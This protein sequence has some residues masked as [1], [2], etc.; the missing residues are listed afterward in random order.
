ML[1][2][3]IGVCLQ[4]M[5]DDIAY[6]FCHERGIIV[7]NVTLKMYLKP[8]KKKATESIPFRLRHLS[9]LASLRG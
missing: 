2:K 5:R 7:M 1:I 4:L 8:I 3:R 9:F 6:S